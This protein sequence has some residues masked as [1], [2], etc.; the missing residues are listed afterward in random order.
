MAAL[1]TTPPTNIFNLPGRVRPPSELRNQA[2]ESS[3]LVGLQ[4]PGIDLNQELL[5]TTV[6]HWQQVATASYSETFDP[7]ANE[8]DRIEIG[9][10][11]RHAA[12]R[13]EAVIIASNANTNAHQEKLN[14]NESRAHAGEEPKPSTVISVL[15]H[16]GLTVLF[17]FAFHD[18]FYMVNS[19]WRWAAALAAA[20][21]ISGIPVAMILNKWSL[22]TGWSWI[23][24][25]AGF[26]LVLGQF[27]FRYYF[28]QWAFSPA[29]A[30]CV[31]ELAILGYLE[32]DAW[33][34]HRKY[35]EF[36]PHFIAAEAAASNATAN[37]Q[38]ASEHEAKI[39]AIDVYSMDF[40]QYVRNRDI[41][42]KNHVAIVAA[43]GQ[44]A[45]LAFRVGHNEKIRTM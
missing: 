28:A 25:I 11:D 9:T 41:W 1:A 14:E 30:P 26:F 24:L 3:K 44:A 27:I 13:K 34:L 15:A 4:A 38:R 23:G 10:F 33:K 31:M 42:A 8:A 2:Y 16:A 29:V 7:N 22:K 21:I 32:F 12:E 43:I 40:I 36:A 45:D 5:D 17:S 6:K 35:E 37:L 20:A 19:E 39:R 18:A